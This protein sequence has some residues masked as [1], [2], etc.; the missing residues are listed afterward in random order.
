MHGWGDVHIAL[1]ALSK[2]GKWV[3]MGDLITDDMLDAFA[4]VAEPGD[5]ASQLN[6]RYGDIATRVMVELPKSTDTELWAGV[7]AELKK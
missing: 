3:E 2:Q 5:L 6:G 1:N 4:I 7:L